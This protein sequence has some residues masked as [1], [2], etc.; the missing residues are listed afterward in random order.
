MACLQGK[1]IKGL[2]PHNGAQAPATSHLTQTMI[3]YFLIPL[4][5]IILL[6]IF[7]VPAPAVAFYRSVY[8]RRKVLPPDDPEL[9]RPTMEPFMGRLKD[10]YLYLM[11]KKPTQVSITAADGVVLCGDRYEQ[12]SSKTVLM[13]H[14]YNA[15]PYV[16][17]APQARW[18]YD[19]GYDLLVIYQRGHSKSGG[20]H[21]GMGLLEKDDVLQWA[22]FISKEHPGQKIMIYGISMGGTAVA[23]CSDVITNPDVRCAVIDCGFISPYGQMKR[24]SVRFHLPFR[25]IAPY[26][27]AMVKHGLHVDLRERT[28]DHLKNAKIPIL[29]LHGDADPTVPLEQAQRNYDACGSEKT[30]VT[31]ADAAHTTA[32]LT[33]EAKAARAYIDFM[34]KYFN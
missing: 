12:N 9:K 1:V 11:S 32:F 20:K 27:Q 19:N 4:I 15:D 10:D 16:N 25:L 6:Y 21:T 23:Y 26:M 31:V 13:V 30:L 14:G 18:F 5:L 7:L 22:D 3:L 2:R 29:F 34:D 24:E 8:G 17:L 28:D 33:D